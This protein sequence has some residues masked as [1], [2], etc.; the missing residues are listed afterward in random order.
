M[1]AIVNRRD[2]RV[3]GSTLP[4]LL[5]GGDVEAL[6]LEDPDP[7]PGMA[8]QHARRIVVEGQRQAMVAARLGVSRATVSVAVGRGRLRELER[9]MRGL[10]GLLVAGISA[11]ERHGPGRVELPGPVPANRRAGMPAFGCGLCGGAVST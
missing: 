6:L 11:G 10:H 8:L 2:R 7:V 4:G 1:N 9:A 3:P 5:H